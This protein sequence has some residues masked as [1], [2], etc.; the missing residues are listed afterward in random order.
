MSSMIITL[1][2]VGIIVGFEV[3]C[4]CIEGD[5][6][7]K[8]LIIAGCLDAGLLCLLA[9]LPLSIEVNDRGVRVNRVIGSKTIKYGDIA[10]TGLSYT[11]GALKLCGSGGFFG[12]L[13]W[14]KAEGF[15]VYFSYVLDKSQAF[16][17][18]LKDGKRYMLSC[19]NPD[20]AIRLIRGRI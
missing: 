20:E 13:G 4:F 12:N 2:V 16:Y 10:E 18:V 19:D 8:E 14:Y 3:Y 17:I 5:Y 7:A 9:L 6:S 15:G 11:P 1:V